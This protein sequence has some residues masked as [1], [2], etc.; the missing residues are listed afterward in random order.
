MPYSPEL[1][2]RYSLRLQAEAQELNRKAADAQLLIAHMRIP[3]RQKSDGAMEPLRRWTAIAYR[4]HDEPY[5]HSFEPAPLT[6][7]QARLM[8][9]KGLLL[10]AQKR[11]PEMT[12][13]M[14]MSPRHLIHMIEQVE[15][16][17]NHAA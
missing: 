9:R 5:W 15:Y 12:T 3:D 4:R 7:A 2:R 11:L 16:G 14:V 8:V 10:M 1:L 17:N 13:L 6:I